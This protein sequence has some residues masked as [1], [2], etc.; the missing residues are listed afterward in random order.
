MRG[1]EDGRKKKEKY[2]RRQGR[3]RK[4]DGEQ[5]GGRR[6]GGEDRDRENRGGDSEKKREG[7]TSISHTD[8]M[9]R[10]EAKGKGKK[11]SEVG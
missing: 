2:E 9:A 11:G 10:D 7:P 5:G 4:E 3:K 1:W 6:N 8:M